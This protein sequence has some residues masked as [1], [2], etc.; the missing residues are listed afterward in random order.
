MLAIEVEYLLGRSVA[1]DTSQRDRTEWPPHPARLFSALVDALADVRAEE[2]EATGACEA[3][4]RWLE[5]LPSPE[6]KASVSDDV[7][8]RSPVKFWVPINDEPSDKMRSAPLVDQRKRQERFFPAAVPAD[9]K[10]VFVWGAEPTAEQARAI[11][12]LAARVPY[13]GHSSSVV[14]VARRAEGTTTNLSLAGGGMTAYRMRVPGPGR[15]DRLDAVHSVRK[16]D[17]LVQPPKGRE[18]L[19]RTKGRVYPCGPLGE[20]RVVALVGRRI[21][22]EHA[23]PLIARF[24][25]ALLAHLGDDAPPVLTGHE[26]GSSIARPHLAFAPLANVGHEHADGTIKGIA[27]YLPRDIDD[28]HVLRL[29]E[30]L[31]RVTLDFGGT[32]VRP[33]GEATALES[34]DTRRYTH[35]SAEWAS[36]MPVVLGRY[37]RK[38]RRLVEDIVARDVA[39][40]VDAPIAEVVAQDVPFVLGAARATETVRGRASAVKNRVVCHV[41]LRFKE[42]VEGPILVGAGRYMGFGLLMPVRPRSSRGGDRA[43][44]KLDPRMEGSR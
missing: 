30:V 44:F 4:L 9:P 2:A 10:V 41:Y 8:F 42:P 26:N 1:T 32:R 20:A 11:D 35:P 37:P 16:K 39:H 33:L 7:S 14:R 24:R 22:I 18:V 27:L 3:A 31:S 19:Y 40:V 29:E 12:T 43:S 28:D 38:N 6:L 34:L 13:L 25:A 23:A 15:L 17:T 36:V 21:S 5:A